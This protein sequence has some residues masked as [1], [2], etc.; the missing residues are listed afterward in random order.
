MPKPNFKSRKKEGGNNKLAIIFLT[1]IIVIGG[2]I[3]YVTA[4]KSHTDT[5][6]LNLPSYAYTTDQVTQAYV[7]SVKMSDV[8]H[9]MPCY[10]GCSAMDHMNLRDCFRYENGEWDQHAAG[11]DT[12]VN[13]AL[14][15]WAQIN[16][17]KSPIDVRNTIDNQ[18]SNGD[19][20]PSTP[21]PMPP[22]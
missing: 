19:Y 4:M 5:G 9:Y 8:F 21:T 16:E 20:Q 13:I 1:G 10:C 18:Y 17:G 7:A 11:C 6:D 14:T 3:F 15:V 2:L 12:C 22:A